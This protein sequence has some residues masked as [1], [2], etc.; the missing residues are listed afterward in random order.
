MSANPAEGGEMG[1]EV[2]AS[3]DMG[4]EMGGDTP[5]PPAAPAGGEPLMEIA[6]KTKKRNILSM[7]NEDFDLDDLFD[8][9]KAQK[10]IKEINARLDNILN[11]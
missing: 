5:V 1:G 4:A 6:T 9:E 11:D 2:G 3:L 7:L 8:M 10:N